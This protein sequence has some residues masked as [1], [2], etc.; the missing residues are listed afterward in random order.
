MQRIKLHLGT[1]RLKFFG[2]V[3]VYGQN[4]C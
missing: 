4:K 3:S 2:C 1:V